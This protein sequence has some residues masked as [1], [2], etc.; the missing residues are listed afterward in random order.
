[1][2]VPELIFCGGN[3]PRF[4][5]IAIA[6]G[7]RYGCELT[8]DTPY[9]P[10]YFA[11]QDWTAHR[12]AVAAGQGDAFRVRYMARL[13]QYRPHMATVLD[14]ERQDQLT[15]VLIWA[16]EAAAL[17]DQV[18]IIPKVPSWNNPIRQIPRTIGGRSVVLAYSVPTRYGGT[19]LPLSYFTGWPVHL[20]G[21]SPH[22]QMRLCRTFTALGAT[23]VSVDGNMH[24]KEANRLCAFWRAEKGRKGHWVQ[25]AEVGLGDYG[26]NSNV[27]A[28][29]RSCEN[30]AAAWRSL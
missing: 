20:L 1:M 9:A 24:Q 21:G 10:V 19:P 22:E 12:R 7:F 30:I 27:E 18:L 26:R 16:E 23:V 17:V 2:P 6:A 4:A 15:E 14:W 29:R 11:D 25:L 13:A 8:G 5:E 28:F 3:N